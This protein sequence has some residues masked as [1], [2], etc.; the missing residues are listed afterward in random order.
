MLLFHTERALKECSLISATLIHPKI[1]A[2]HPLWS[3]FFR[4]G[5][6]TTDFFFFNHS[7]ENP[8]SAVCQVRKTAVQLIKRVCQLLPSAKTH[9]TVFQVSP[10]LQ[11]LC[12]TAWALGVPSFTWQFAS[13][14]GQQQGNK[15][16]L[17]WQQG[18]EVVV[19]EIMTLLSYSFSGSQCCIEEP[20]LNT[21]CTYVE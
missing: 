16:Q 4:K 7:L 15:L 11:P 17:L 13:R 10:S 21:H 18:L 19:Q 6:K 12:A 2:G 8:Q 9:P 1:F 20:K 5:K 14:A 3:F